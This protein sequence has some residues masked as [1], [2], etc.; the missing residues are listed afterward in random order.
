[1]IEIVLQWKFTWKVKGINVIWPSTYPPMLLVQNWV[2]PKV[3]HIVHTNMYRLKYPIQHRPYNSSIYII[4]IANIFPV[5]MILLIWYTW[6]C[7]FLKT[8][9]QSCYLWCA[10]AVMPIRDMIHPHTANPK[11]YIGYWPIGWLPTQSLWCSTL[12][13][14]PINSYKHLV[15]HTSS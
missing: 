13:H 7:G 14:I 5:F 1:M 3:F 15:P 8:I 6:Y 4:N 9:N 12:L 10:D 2:S 11:L